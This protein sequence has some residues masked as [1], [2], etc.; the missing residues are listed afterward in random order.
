MQR[1]T[2]DAFLSYPDAWQGDDED[3]QPSSSTATPCTWV[4]SAWLAC[5]LL[6]YNKL[7]GRS[8]S[9]L[10]PTKAK[11][12]TVDRVTPYYS[13]LPWQ[14]QDCLCQVAGQ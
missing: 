8:L 10:K 2:D 11:K 1:A 13:V 4:G 9:N 7:T 6:A 12:G 5:L 14:G 3:G